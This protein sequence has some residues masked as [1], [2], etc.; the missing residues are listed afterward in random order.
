[1]SERA[2]IFADFNDLLSSPQRVWLDSVGAR[3]DLDRLG[4]ELTEGLAIIVYDHDL[5]AEGNRDDILADA[6]VERDKE[7]GRWVAVI[8][9]DTLRHLSDEP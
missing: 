1:V 7:T 5:D 2:R 9:R 6:V 3:K 8:D 4:V